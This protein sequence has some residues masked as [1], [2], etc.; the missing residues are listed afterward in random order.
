MVSKLQAELKEARSKRDKAL[1]LL[2]ERQWEDYGS[3][4]VMCYWCDAKYGSLHASDC[5]AALAC[6]WKRDI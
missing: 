2:S 4:Q 5:D 1:Y 3:G 6:G